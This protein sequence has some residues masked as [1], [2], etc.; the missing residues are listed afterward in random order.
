MYDIPSCIRLMPGPEDA[1]ITRMPADAAPYTMLMAD[2]SL[3][4]CKNVPPT[5]GKRRAAYSAISL[6]GV[7]G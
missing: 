5:S 1:D 3:S 7:I 6:A 4:D 2:T